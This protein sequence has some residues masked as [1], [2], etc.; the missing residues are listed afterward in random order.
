MMEGDFVIFK[1]PLKDNTG[2]TAIDAGVSQKQT[3]VVLEQMN[4]LVEGVIGKV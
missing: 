4:Y 1:G 3:E 2:K